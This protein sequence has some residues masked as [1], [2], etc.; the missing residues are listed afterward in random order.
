MPDPAVQSTFVVER[1]F[2]ASSAK[3]FA[4]FADPEIKRRWF[5]E[6]LGHDTE[7]FE[8]EFKVG[9]EERLRY[10]LGEDTPVPG[11]VLDN[12][13]ILLDIVPE[14]R[15]V[16]AS[17]MRAADRCVSAS[18][19]TIE[20]SAAGE[21]THLQCT[22]HGAFFEGSDGPQMREMGWNILMDQLGATLT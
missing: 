12:H 16:A 17:T 21:G 19:V 9:G 4:A 10:R 15:I 8:M 7:L 5:A 22:H 20:L 3:V 14:E 1:T 18:L 2:A 11:L 6:G 13:S